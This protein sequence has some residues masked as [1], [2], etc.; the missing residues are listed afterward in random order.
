M[1]A[2]GFPW[3]SN[4][5]SRR[6]RLIFATVVALAAAAFLATKY[7]RFPHTRSDF[8]QVRF[9]AQ[10][11]LNGSNPYVLA[12]PD[13]VFDNPRSV[14]YPATAFVAAIPFTFV[15]DHA[16]SVIFV[17]ISAFL[18]AYGATA[19]S[20]HLL[21]IFPSIGFFSSLQFAQW[22]TLTTAAEFLPWIALIGA[23]KPQSMFPIVVSS[24]RWKPA[25]FAVAGG[26]VLLAIS[27]LLFLSCPREWLAAIEGN[28]DLVPPLFRLGGPV[29]LLA[30]LKWRRADAWL[31]VLL[32][33]MPQTW[34]WYNT[35]ILLTIARTY[36]EACVLSLVS[37]LGHLL[38]LY[39]LQNSLPE[40]YPVWGGAM[41]AF[42]YLPATIAILRRPNVGPGP[43]FL[44]AI[45]A[46]N[47]QINSPG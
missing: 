19:G 38:T 31:V 39:F 10:A 18:L 14:L 12:G 30:L 41:V 32:A 22:S 3:G 42:A 46:R 21:P 47:G 15:S 26:L 6:Q 1:N 40:S 20:W 29:I 45:V 28:R 4:R 27:L 8:S 25:I 24:E 9:G 43:A 7:H 35:L 11:L 36:R 5:P 2:E 17:A 44:E 33:C 34:A 23:V 37:S 13:R 16:A